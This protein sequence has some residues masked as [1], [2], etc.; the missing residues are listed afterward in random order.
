[1][2]RF[3]PS[4]RAV[5]LCAFLSATL[6]AGLA[7]AGNTGHAKIKVKKYYDANADGIRN[8]GEPVLQGWLMT[9]T[10]ASRAID[11]TLSTD[12]TG[13]ARWLKVM[14]GNDYISPASTGAMR[15]ARTSILP[16]TLPS[17]RGCAGA[18]RSTWPTSSRRTWPR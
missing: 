14:P 15:M 5:A 12:A 9:L 11:S 1:M 10:S 7:F 6:I 4:R 2:D 8:A 16:I 17:A 13:V 18:R 3:P